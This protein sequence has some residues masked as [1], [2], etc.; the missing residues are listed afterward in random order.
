M[1][2]DLYVTDDLVDLGIDDSDFSVVLFRVLAPVTDVNEL[3]L[4][5]ID[6]V[7]RS[8]FKMDRIEKF[9]RVPSEY[10]EHAVIAACQKQLIQFRHEQCSL[11]FL[12]SGDTAYPLAS[13]QVH[14]LKG[15]IFQPRNKQ[16]FTFDIHIHVVKA[17][18]N[19]RDR[20]RLHESKRLLSTLLRKRNPAACNEADGSNYADVRN[21]VHR[22]A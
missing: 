7:V 18:F 16:A 13:L 14:H 1:S 9:E 8:Q 5:F 22:L 20:N 2:H 21:P 3:R 19:I 15:A 12:K 10:S 4:G 6:Q 11:C 17:A